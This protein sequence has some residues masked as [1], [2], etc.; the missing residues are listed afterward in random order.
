MDNRN[1]ISKDLTAIG[2]V[3]FVLSL[4]SFVSVFIA[5]VEMFV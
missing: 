1:K 5:C 3:G 2:N 4:L